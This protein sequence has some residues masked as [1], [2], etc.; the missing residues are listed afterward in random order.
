MDFASSLKNISPKAMATVKFAPDKN[1]GKGRRYTFVCW[2]SANFQGKL[3]VIVLV[4]GK[5]PL[6]FLSE[7][8]I[9]L[10]YFANL[11]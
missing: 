3:A 5:P 7:S 11:W 2:D 10:F 6:M 4:E 1:G 8:R 9:H